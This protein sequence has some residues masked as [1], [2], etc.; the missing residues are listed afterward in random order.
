MRSLA[1]QESFHLECPVGLLS[2]VLLKA[3]TP[4]LPLP[5]LPL[6][7]PKGSC[8]VPDIVV[9][10]DYATPLLQER[11]L[12]LLLGPVFTLSFAVLLDG[13]GCPRGSERV[14]PV[15]LPSVLGPGVLGPG[16]L[17]LASAA[18]LC[19]P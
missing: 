15:A 3:D 19:R 6:P 8:D 18:C 5:G 2:P 17:G 16:I 12:F 11:Q 14:L 9:E 4:A 1:G 10:H 7:S 13:R